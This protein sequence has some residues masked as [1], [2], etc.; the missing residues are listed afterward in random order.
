MTEDDDEVVQAILASAQAMGWEHVADANAHDSERIGFTPST[1]RHGKRTSAYSAFVRPVRSRHNLT[2]AT[3]TRA[4]HLLFDGTRVVG[5]RASKA[6]QT[7]DYRAR[8]EV[9]V[10]AGTVE[11]T[12][13]L[14]RSGIG[15]PDVLHRAGID[16]RVDSPNV[17]ERVI[18]QR[19]V[20]IQ[21]RLNAN[22]GPTQRLNTVPN[23]GWQGFKYL[24]TRSG[25][26][27]TGGYDLVSQ[28]KSSPDL[29]RPTSRAS[30]CRWRSTPAAR[31]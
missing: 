3:R 17:G 21:V 7:V 18:E 1:I 31:P 28:F 5:V 16:L 27:A 9:I 15:R 19:A 6:G 29:D 2:V 26:I 11:T 14:E 20:S 24:F 8:K 12:L 10:S 4:G 22:I 30:S 23:R 13:L 25:P